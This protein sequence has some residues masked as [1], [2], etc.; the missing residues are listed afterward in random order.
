[1]VFAAGSRLALTVSTWL[2]AAARC[3]AVNPRVVSLAVTLLCPSMMSCSH[4]NL[5]PLL[6]AS[7]RGVTPDVS[8][9][10]ASA[11]LSISSS[12]ESVRWKGGEGGEYDIAPQNLMVRDLALVKMQKKIYIGAN[13]TG[14]RAAASPRASLCHIQRHCGRVAEQ[15]SKV[16]HTKYTQRKKKLDLDQLTWSTAL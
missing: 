3:S 9:A 15:E 4:A 8:A 12:C 14:W 13:V 10:P 2:F 16:D 1:V 11:P 5:K 6:A 7:M